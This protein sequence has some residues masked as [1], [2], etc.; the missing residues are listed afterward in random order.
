MQ[1]GCYKEGGC[2]PDR[3]IDEETPVPTVVVRNPAA[4]GWAQGRCDDDAEDENRLNQTLL[5]AGE[6]L[7]DRRLRGG[8]ERGTACA[9]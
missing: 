9:L 7:T 3:D 5:I 2:Y 6:D 1:E 8:Q 4:E